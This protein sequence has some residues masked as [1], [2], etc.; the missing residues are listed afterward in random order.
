MGR[1]GV[2]EWEVCHVRANKYTGF[3]GEKANGM[4]FLK[5]RLPG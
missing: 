1:M 2:G 5:L 4:G 3:A